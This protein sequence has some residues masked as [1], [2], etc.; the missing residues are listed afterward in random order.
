[1]KLRKELTS[2]NKNLALI[3]LNIRGL[4]NK[5][6]LLKELLSNNLGTIQ[7]DVILLCETWLNTNNFDSVNIPNYK[8]M[9]NIRNGRIGG[10]TGVLVH[11]SLKCREKKDL[12]VLS[13]TFE[14]TVVELKTETNNILLVWGYRPPNRNTY[15]FV[16]DY[17]LPLRTWQKLKHHD[18]VIGMDHNL[19]FLKSD[20]HP[21]IQ[22]FLELNLDNDMMPT[23]TRPTRVMRTSVTL[24][25]NVMISRKLHAHYN[26]L[27]LI[28]DISDHFPSVVFLHNQKCAKREAKRIHTR[29]VN[30]TKISQIKNKLNVVNWVE[31]LS[32]QNADITFSSFHT[33]LVET[34][35]TVIPEKIKT[36]SYKWMT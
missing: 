19:D 20:K 23:I 31:K 29:E 25:D 13:T 2:N 3:Q 5:T 9:G 16:R 14:H 30:D 10:G 34:I 18:V 26:S 35:E 36:I 21:Q 15:K 8:L 24:I 6:T 27:I 12:E 7:L 32:D 33:K 4:H 1:M 11:E 28:D 17:K 22:Q